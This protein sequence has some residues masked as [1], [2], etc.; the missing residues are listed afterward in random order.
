MAI[1][2]D[3]W[4]KQINMWLTSVVWPFLTNS[5]KVRLIW[6]ASAHIFFLFKRQNNIK[7]TH[8]NLRQEK[9]LP[10]NLFCH[11]KYCLNAASSCFW[12]TSMPI[13]AVGK[14]QVKSLALTG[15]LPQERKKQAILW[16]MQQQEGWLFAVGQP[17]DAWGHTQPALALLPLHEAL[18]EVKYA[19]RKENKRS[20]FLSS[21]FDNHKSP[22][23]PIL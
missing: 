20:V 14:S 23:S 15:H 21:S 7:I 11:F 3:I 13:N 5:R 16:P 6:T 19:R 4:F 22:W 8:P 9:H 10:L 17:A 1:Y 12:V 2:N 18:I